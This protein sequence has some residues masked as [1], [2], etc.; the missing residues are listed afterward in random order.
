MSLVLGRAET[1]VERSHLGGIGLTLLSIL[2]FAGTNALAKW[3]NH[4]VPV[5]EVLFARAALGVLLIAPFVSR[6]DIAAMVAGGRPWL[7]ALRVAASAVEVCCF[8]WAISD[9]P[10]A[11]GSTIYLAGLVYV[12]ALSAVFLRERVGWRRWAAVVV[13]FVGVLVALRP[14][15][16]VMTPHALVAVGGSVL[17]A[18]SLVATRRLRATPNTL[19]A[20]T[21]MAALLLLSGASA[22]AGWVVPDVAEAALMAVV[23]VVSLLAYLCVNRGLQLAPASVVA[24]FNYASILGAVMLGYMMFGDVPAPA[25]LVGAAIIVCAGLFILL[26][27]DDCRWNHRK[28]ESRDK[29]KD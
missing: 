13:G 25:T 3:L 1:P 29:T 21:Q 12:T 10:L 28:S 18:V 5:G 9:L 14:A 22:A 19:L 16:A 7:H 2:M 17:Y 15:G 6:R 26:E 20:G 11:D 27:R 23:G 24:P 4:A 8:Y